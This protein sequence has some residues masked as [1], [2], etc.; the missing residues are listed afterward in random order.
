MTEI[1]FKPN[2]VAS[3]KDYPLA[4]EDLKPGNFYESSQDQY[5][6]GIMRYDEITGK[7]IPEAINLSNGCG[8]YT[9]YSGMRFKPVPRGI[10]EL[11]ID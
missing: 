7:H 4:I 11:T 2:P 9:K 3:V 1:K 6:I 10:L 8:G 5:V